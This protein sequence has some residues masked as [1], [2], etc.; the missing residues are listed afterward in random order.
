MRNTGEGLLD[1]ASRLNREVTALNLAGQD[2]AR[3]AQVQAQAVDATRRTRGVTQSD[4]I[5]V[6][7]QAQSLAQSP[8]DAARI[9]DIG[10]RYARATGSTEHLRTLIQ[11]GHHLPSGMSHHLPSGMSMT[12]VLPMK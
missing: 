7:N 6:Y 1:K 2:A 10:T 4:Y 5:S 9:A 8:A 12:P 3:I 11:A